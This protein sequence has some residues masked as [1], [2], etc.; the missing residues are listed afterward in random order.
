MDA[1]TAHVFPIKVLQTQKRFMGWFLCKPHD[2][3]AREF[4]SRVC[5]INK[6]LTKFPLTDEEAKLPRYELLD[7]MEFGIPS[8][9]QKAMI[10]QDFDPANHT[11]AEFIGFCKC[12][13]LTEPETNRIEKKVSFNHDQ[14]IPKKRISCNFWGLISGGWLIL[15]SLDSTFSDLIL[16]FL[17]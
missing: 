6:L 1:V 4:V 7:L 9:W 2:M 16:S 17:N 5:E 14:T 12:L 11:I 13:E 8:S 10:L 3:K 15:S